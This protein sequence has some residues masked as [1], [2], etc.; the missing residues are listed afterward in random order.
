MVSSRCVQ[1]LVCI[2]VAQLGTFDAS[3]AVTRKTAEG[4][5][6][7]A[8]EQENFLP[9]PA[10]PFARAATPLKRLQS[11]LQA[12]IDHVAISPML[13][14]DEAS[15]ASSE[16]EERDDLALCAAGK[17]NTECDSASRVKTGLMAAALFASSY[18]VSLLSEVVVDE[19][20]Q[21]FAILAA[22]VPA[23]FAFAWRQ[24]KQAS[25]QIM[26]TKGKLNH[27]LAS[28]IRM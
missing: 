2:L 18:A 17:T 4:V 19:G 25:S 12:S 3:C 9:K 5:V 20:L 16:E 8:E 27:G 15:S 14:E 7:Q 22:V 13:L 6:Q 23:G 28:L 1:P 21:E 24:R 10:K 11:A 26:G